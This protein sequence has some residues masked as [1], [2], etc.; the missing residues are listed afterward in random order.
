[1]LPEAWK[2]GGWPQS[3]EIDIMEHVGYEV[4]AVHHSLHTDA[5]NHMKGTQFT[6]CAG[7]GLTVAKCGTTIAG[8]GVHGFH[9]YGLEW[10]EN[11]FVWTIDGIPTASRTLPAND[12]RV[13]PFVEPF[14]LL[15]NV[16]VGGSWGGLHGV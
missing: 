2:F 3:G 5:E 16:A 9:T 6:H 4:G 14:H 13:N 15:L 8:E 7:V 1:M 11:S 10:G 12:W